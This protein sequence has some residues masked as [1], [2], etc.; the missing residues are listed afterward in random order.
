MKV[1]YD[2]LHSVNEETVERLSY[3]H[4][5][6]VDMGLES[7]SSGCKFNHFPTDLSQEV[8]WWE[9][10]WENQLE[11][12]QWLNLGVMRKDDGWGVVVLPF[13]G[14][15]MEKFLCG[16]SECEM[17]SWII[18]LVL[19]SQFWTGKCR[20]GSPLNLIVIELKEVDEIA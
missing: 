1:S 6:V 13:S 4:N 5:Q 18:D 10:Y 3:L 8:G 15:R 7:I 11:S 12:L 16:G 20:F 17:S 2:R 19:S 14:R 9:G